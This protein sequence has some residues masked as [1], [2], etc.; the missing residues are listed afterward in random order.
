LYPERGDLQKFRV[1]VPDLAVA[2]L[3]KKNE[4]VGMR[5]STSTRHHLLGRNGK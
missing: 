5:T 1:A 4:K 2:M 3:T